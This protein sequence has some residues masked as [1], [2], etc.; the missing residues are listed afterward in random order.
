MDLNKIIGSRKVQIVALVALLS[1]A[2]IFLRDLNPATLDL[3]L[4]IEFVGGVRIP[5]SLEHSVDSAT[6]DSMV[7]L[8]KQ[9]INK[10]GLSQAI[11]RPLGDKDIL[12][13]IPRAD[14]SVIDSVER[15]LREQGRFEA[16]ID[17]RQALNGSDILS[18]SVG[19]GT[20]ERVFASTGGFSY[21][22]GFAATRTGAEKFASTAK[23]K[24]HYPVYMFLDRPANAVVL[25]EKSVLN[26]SRSLLNTKATNEALS[27]Q[28]DVIEL[29]FVDGNTSIASAIANKTT[30]IMDSELKT[31][32]P[33]VYQQ[34]ISAGFSEQNASK[35]LALKP[36]SDM[37]PTT[38]LTEQS[39]TVVN[40][41]HAIG[42]L[43]GP[44][45]SPGLAEGFV[46]QFY[47][48]TGSGRGSTPEQ[49]R[50]GAVDEVK[51]LKIVISGGK[52]PVSTVV[53][54]SYSIA[55]SLGK[56]FLYYSAV[57]IVLSV[58]IV[59]F[60]IIFRYRR[61]ALAVPIIIINAI[62]MLITLAVIGTFGTLDLAG[63]A[64]V[65][66]LIG[67]GVD[68]QIIITDEML[69]KKKSTEDDQA[70]PLDVRERLGRAFEVVMTNASIAI[71]AML[72][73]LLLSGLVEIRGFAL[74]YIVGVLVGVL[75]TRPAFGVIIGE[76]FGEQTQQ[77]ARSQ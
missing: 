59:A 71:V 57:G 9:R 10:N 50:Q 48:V 8:I 30:V 39:D 52:L 46:S 75:I 47:Q 27:K 36:S 61:P 44:T 12:V 77:T 41:W 40:S 42:L 76:L 33:Q 64:G 58:A 38:Y 35:R 34:A 18:S 17:G 68:D 7:E 21:E 43:S 51:L 56:Q 11:V 22:L 3:N 72:P 24:A 62:E 26:S 70:R 2:A 32:L 73:L 28:G 23:G 63:M 53:G 16:V 49:Q 14:P 60:L 6:M 31:R 54:S 1:L 74:A 69:R 29:V 19:G 4:G 13:E 45:L 15:L 5:V 55:A 67:T 65:I 66:T 25:L 37:L 20:N